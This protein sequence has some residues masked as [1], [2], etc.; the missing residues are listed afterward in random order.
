[1]KRSELQRLSWICPH[2]KSP[3]TLSGDCLQCATCG[4][5]YL[6]DD[7]SVR[8]IASD[9]TGAPASSESFDNRLRNFFKRWP[10]VYYFIATVFGPLMHAGVSAHDFIDRYHG[11]G[12]ALN[13]GSGPR[14]IHEKVL[15]ID[16]IHFKD[17]DVQ[18]DIGAVPLATASIQAIVCDTLME[19]ALEP[20][21]LLGEVYRLLR[22]GGSAYFTVPFLYPY[23][24]SPEDITRWTQE[25]FTRLLKAHGFIVEK[26]G[27]RAGAFSTLTV[28]LCYLFALVFSF[29]SERL[30]WVLMN[31]SIFIFF[32]IKFLDIFV[33]WMPASRHMASVLY[34]IVRKP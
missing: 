18:A 17:V 11:D 13:L 27:I 10:A 26:V 28:S 12:I 34:Y 33:N 6:W 32:P 14:R 3:L 16:L 7:E 30:F 29:N 4:R 20:D 23:H 1:M 24:A 22:S 25:G 2:C 31:V 5:S 9:T 15:N 19:H 8:F 21:R